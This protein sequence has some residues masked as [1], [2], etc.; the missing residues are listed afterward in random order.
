MDRRLHKLDEIV[1]EKCTESNKG[2]FKYILLSLK[3][4]WPH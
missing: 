2:G 3:L 1:L 4:D